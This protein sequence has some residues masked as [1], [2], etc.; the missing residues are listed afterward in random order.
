MINIVKL[1]GCKRCGGDLFLDRDSDGIFLSCLQCS[2]VYVRRITP[3][4]K[5][6]KLKK[7]YAR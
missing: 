4:V 5:R 6:P 7:M 2:A 1:K 3:F